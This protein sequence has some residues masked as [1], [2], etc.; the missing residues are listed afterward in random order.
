MLGEGEETLKEGRV[1]GAAMLNLRLPARPPEVLP[2]RK[3]LKKMREQ[4]S[5]H[6]RI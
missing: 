4:A 1:R 6:R 3:D 2:L 5:S